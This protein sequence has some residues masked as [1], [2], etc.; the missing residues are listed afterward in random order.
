VVS[1]Q[2][3]QEWKE[4]MGREKVDDDDYEVEGSLDDDEFRHALDDEVLTALD[5]HKA[6]DGEDAESHR[7]LQAVNPDDAA[8]DAN[9][10]G[11][12]GGGQQE[13]GKVPDLAHGD[14]HSGDGSK[15]SSAQQDPLEK[16]AED[17]ARDQ[18][19]EDPNAAH[20]QRNEKEDEESQHQNREQDIHAGEAAADAEKAGGDSNEHPHQDH[21]REEK[22]GTTEKLYDDDMP[23]S[24]DGVGDVD[25]FAADNFRGGSEDYGGE[26]VYRGDDIAMDDPNYGRRY[27]DDYARHHDYDDYYG[28]RSKEH[29]EYYDSKHYFRIPPHILCTPVLAEIPKLYSNEHE[30]DD[31]LLVAVSYYLDEDEYEG[32]FSYK[33]FEKQ[34]HG[35]ET[36]VKRGAY[37]ASAIMIYILGDSP[38]WS[39]QVHL[40]LSTDYSAP[41]NATLVGALPIRKDVS[42]MGAFSLGS[43]TVADIDG[44]GNFEV[45]VG[46]SM[47]IIYCF[48]ARQMY[49]KDKWPVQMKRPIE[50]RILVE[51][52]VGDTNLEVFVADISANIICLSHEGKP[53]WYRSLSKSL[54]NNEID[55]TKT[56]EMTVGD[57][58]GDGVLDLV[59]AV[60]VRDRSFVFALNAATGKDLANFPIELERQLIQ[61]N[62]VHSG[63][64][65]L[66]LTKPLLVDLHADQTFLDDY[67]RRNGTRWTPRR[68]ASVTA[69]APPHGGSA[70]GLHIVFPQAEM[71]YIIEG[72]SG[73]SQ[74]ISI[75]DPVSA[76]IQVD[77]V[78]G[79]N[80]LDLVVSTESGDIITL[81]SATPYHPLNTWSHGE[82]RGRMNGLVHGFSASQGIFV[83]EMSRQYTDIFGVYVPITFEIFDNRPNIRNEPN[84]RKYLV[85]VRAGTSSKRALFRAEYNET[86]VF[87]ERVYIRFGP[88]YYSLNLVMM[89]SHGLMY[90]DTFHVG[91]N[92]HFMS[93]FSALLWLPLLVASAT[94][95][96]CGVKKAS[97]DDQGSETEDEG[98]MPLLGRDIP[99]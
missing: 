89:T 71:L 17:S 99:S 97:W 39:G 4:R 37:V 88:G 58:D 87:T 52:V 73:C 2:K 40:D 56:S 26:E 5:E 36:E 3:M 72:G 54:G 22:H 15:G 45:L 91:Y 93:G 75:G 31:I 8:A 50:S 74:T 85:E 82:L 53:I 61:N 96:F 57:V 25:D 66:K 9:A 94:I 83:H 34:D 42:K 60:Q 84:K 92:V 79:T 20:G 47:G 41:E 76:M 98:Q 23:A 64:Y 78:H 29:E 68:R 33:R 32:L 12:D 70:A 43:P 21:V 86:G 80:R 1:K 18:R 55:V 90:E 35:D 28:G 59:I 81:E 14:G 44:D 11:G 51:D 24:R 69:S 65:Y 38:R 13:V 48:D 27:D 95:F 62:R 63:S 67:I 7:R 6:A 49:K 19:Q 16:R 46:T 30:K 77:D 10:A